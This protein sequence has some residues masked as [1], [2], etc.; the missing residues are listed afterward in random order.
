MTA[1]ELLLKV[2][3]TSADATMADVHE[4]L[5]ECGFELTVLEEPWNVLFYYHRDWD[6]RLTF[7]AES[8]SVPR[9]LLEGILSFLRFRLSQEGQ[10]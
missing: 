8:T 9:S 6:E 7:P 3:T 2:S 10:L 5:T 1:Q 4:L